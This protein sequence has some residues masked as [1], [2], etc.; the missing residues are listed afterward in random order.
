M[1]ASLTF[2]ELGQQL[3]KKADTNGT[4]LVEAEQF[5]EFLL[6][7]G[8]VLRIGGLETRRG[9]SVGVV[10]AESL[11][12]ARAQS[13]YSQI[14]TDLNGMIDES[15]F[16]PWVLRILHGLVRGNKMDAIQRIYE[17]VLTNNNNNNATTTNNNNAASGG[18]GGDGGE[19][20]DNYNSSSGSGSGNGGSRAAALQ[21]RRTSSGASNGSSSVGGGRS[22]TLPSLS[23][24]MSSADVVGSPGGYAAA[25]SPTAALLSMSRRSSMSSRMLTPMTPSLSSGFGRKPTQLVHVDVGDLGLDNVPRTRQ[26]QADARVMASLESMETKCMHAL[27]Q[28]QDRIMKFAAAAASA[29]AAGAGAGAGAG[30]GAGSG[31][32]SGTGKAASSSSSS[33]N[34]SGR[35][36]PTRHRPVRRQGSR[37]N[38]NGSTEAANGEGAGSTRTGGADGAG[39]GAVAA[40]AGAADE[41]KIHGPGGVG[42]V[43]NQ[44]RLVQPLTSPL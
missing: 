32:G 40:G 21:H 33:S 19:A 34:K 28:I 1:P 42:G 17:Q 41:A 31:S 29:A 13:V 27:D 18:V 30:V 37:A 16:L 8:G 22:P 36:K 3:F 12:V 26:L 2:L 43:D 23:R 20:T 10:S 4:G 35:Q 15:E 24:H 11:M 38:R 6:L 7:Y 9:S 5:V 14:D 25:R 44:V 39:G